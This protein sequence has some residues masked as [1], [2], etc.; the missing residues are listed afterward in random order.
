MYVYYYFN[1]VR[2]TTDGG[3]L[4]IHNIAIFLSRRYVLASQ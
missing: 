3:V 2:F 1:I 4:H